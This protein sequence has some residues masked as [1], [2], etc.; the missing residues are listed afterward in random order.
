MSLISTLVGDRS[1]EQSKDFSNDFFCLVLERRL[2]LL[3][4]LL[5]L[6]DIDEEEDDDLSY[7]RL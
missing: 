5:L 7:L 6:L 3:R 4:E 2:D 1:I